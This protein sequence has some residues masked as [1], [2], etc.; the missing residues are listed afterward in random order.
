M[1]KITEGNFVFLAIM[2]NIYENII[3]LGRRIRI[4]PVFIKLSFSN[5]QI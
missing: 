2:S 1:S 4:R 5:L 3:R